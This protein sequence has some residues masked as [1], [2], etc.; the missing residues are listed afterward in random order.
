MKYCLSACFSNPKM[1]ILP[2]G[3]KILDICLSHISKKQ[4]IPQEK[5]SGAI[6][7]TLIKC[8]SFVK[9]L[10]IQVS[11]NKQLNYFCELYAWSVV[12]VNYFLKKKKSKLPLITSGYHRTNIWL[13]A[14][15]NEKPFSRK[16]KIIEY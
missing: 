2:V 7:P 15:S 10:M 14:S 4:S 16:L 11:L 9:M 6:L 3:V 1:Y 13:S 5:N 12:S 8:I